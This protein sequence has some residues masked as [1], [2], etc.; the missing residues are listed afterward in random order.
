M[1]SQSTEWEE[2]IFYLTCHSLVIVAMMVFGYSLFTLTT[3]SLK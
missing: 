2:V 1:K 3:L